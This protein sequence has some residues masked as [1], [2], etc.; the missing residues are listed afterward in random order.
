MLAKIGSIIKDDYSGT[1]PRK[2]RVKRLRL[3]TPVLRLILRRRGFEL[4]WKHQRGFPQQG[5]PISKTYRP[6][7]IGRLWRCWHA[8]SQQLSEKK[9]VKLKAA[10]PKPGETALKNSYRR[11]WAQR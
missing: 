5:N 8:A 2:L 7:F 1:T 6:G 3:S 10:L 11:I 4:Q 9:V